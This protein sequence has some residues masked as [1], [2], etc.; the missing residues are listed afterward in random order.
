MGPN[1][2]VFSR[3]LVPVSVS[4][5]LAIIDAIGA[6]IVTVHGTAANTVNWPTVNAQAHHVAID[7]LFKLNVSFV[8][9][10]VMEILAKIRD[11]FARIDAERKT[12]V[13]VEV[14]VKGALVRYMYLV[15]KPRR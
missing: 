11:A 1:D 15:M 12:L 5:H 9:G 8:Q 3:R 6:R 4:F 13:L 14:L 2:R 7:V 10:K